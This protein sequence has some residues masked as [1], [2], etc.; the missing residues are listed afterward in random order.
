[1]NVPI[2]TVVQFITDMASGQLGN[3]MS[4]TGT[5]EELDAI[6]LGLNMLAEELQAT[7]VSNAKYL[8]AEKELKRKILE[9]NSLYEISRLENQQEISQ[10][11]YFE[12]ALALIQ[13]ILLKDIHI[14]VILETGEVYKTAGFT[15]KLKPQVH[16]LRV[17]GK[18]WGL[19]EFH[20]TDQRIFDLDLLELWTSHLCG[21]LYK[22]H[23]HNRLMETAEQLRIHQVELEMQNDELRQ[24]QKELEISHDRFS[25]LFEFAPVGYMLIDP[26]GII[27]QANQTAS[28]ML[29]RT[30]QKLVQKPFSLFLR[31]HS[32]EIFFQF[33]MKMFRDN[34][35]ESCDLRLYISATDYLDVSISGSISANAGGDRLCHI[36]LTDITRIKATEKQL[37]I[38]DHAIQSSNNAIVLTDSSGQI[39]Y[40]NPAFKQMWNVPDVERVVGQNLVKYF[41]TEER[42]YEMIANIYKNGQQLQEMSAKGKNNKMF[43]VQ[44]SGSLI[45][46]DVDDPAQ[47]MLS[48]VN[49][50]NQKQLE[51]EL[52]HAQKMESLGHLAGGIAHEFNNILHAMMGFA[53]MLMDNHQDEKTLRYV[54]HILDGGSRASDLIKQILTFSRA[55]NVKYEPLNLSEIVKDSVNMMKSIIPATID[56]QTNLSCTDCMV[57]ANA[58][59]IHQILMNLCTN[60]FHAMP[61][62]GI[63]TISLE[64]IQHK[65]LGKEYDFEWEQ[66]DYVRL[67]IRDTGEGIPEL[68]QKNIFDP[69]FT[70]KEVGSGTGLGLAVVHGIAQA[71]NAHIHLKSKPGK[72]TTIE[73][74]FPVAETVESN[75][76]IELEAPLT[77]NAPVQ[78]NF[79]IVIVEDESVLSKIYQEFLTEKGYDVS[80]FNNGLDAWQFMGENGKFVDLVLTDYSMP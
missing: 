10:D 3:R 34:H 6:A 39:T 47:I 50:T 55:G 26:H 69:F 40:L 72:G 24:T 60:S 53:E 80:L 38:K 8:Q 37:K 73:I 65:T 2:E 75:P 23:N 32:P 66:S 28:H 16:E 29:N 59:Q 45:R 36:N 5:S 70:T 27:K 22:R 58:T 19:I 31:D 46:T 51:K 48:M 43:P 15:K 17:A 54:K 49:L 74:L 9:Q 42:C 63:L 77:E 78:Q 56:I 18:F 35:A 20:G 61:K 76:D 52:L 30:K 25:N 4:V 7:M 44:V 64:R 41:E 57:N 68:I 79:K 1:M 11:E 33:L 62:G 21:F 71:H 13:K 67:S 14:C 12:N